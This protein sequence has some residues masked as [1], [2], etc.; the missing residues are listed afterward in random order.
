MDDIDGVYKSLRQMKSDI[1]IQKNKA[2]RLYKLSEE[3]C[4]SLDSMLEDVIWMTD[5]VSEWASM[6]AIEWAHKAEINAKRIIPRSKEACSLYFIKNAELSL[7][8][9]GISGNV[10]GRIKNMQTSTGY[11]LELGNEIVFDTRTDA[12]N[13]EKFLHDHFAAFR[14]KPQ[15]IKKSSEWFDICILNELMTRFNTKEK[16]LREMEKTRNTEEEQL[17]RV[18][19]L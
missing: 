2:I 8:K 14:R 4:T 6:D 17:S 19:I 16:I 15:K 1:E 5:Q 12:Q 3:L 9:I 10:M 7:V 13:A 18:W 11:Y